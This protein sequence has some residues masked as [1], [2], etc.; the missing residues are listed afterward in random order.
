M[1]GERTVLLWASSHRLNRQIDHVGRSLRT[2]LP[3]FEQ[4]NTLHPAEHVSYL[5]RRHAAPGVVD[6]VLNYFA[7][8]IFGLRHYDFEPD[9]M[10]CRLQLDDRGEIRPVKYPN[11]RNLEDDVA[12]ICCEQGDCLLYEVSLA[13]AHAAHQ[14]RPT[15]NGEGRDF[16]TQFPYLL[17]ANPDPQPLPPP[18]LRER[19]WLILGSSSLAILAFILWPW[20]LWWRIRRRLI[21][22][23][24]RLR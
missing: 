20:L 11:G 13:E 10:I 18:R 19:T 9:V 21:E 1:V 6:D 2:M 12:L 15:T 5:R 24:L 23:E 14:P 4:L 16:L 22:L 3:R 8:S 17:D 7:S